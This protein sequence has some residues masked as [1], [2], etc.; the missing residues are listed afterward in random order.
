MNYLLVLI[1]KGYTYEIEE[2]LEIELERNATVNHLCLV[3]HGIG[4]KLWSNEDMKLIPS[5]KYIN[6]LIS[7]L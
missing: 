3:I 2:N 5:F 4:E 6:I 1:R 7:F